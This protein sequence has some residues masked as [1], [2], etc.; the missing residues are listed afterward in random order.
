MTANQIQPP[1]QPPTWTRRADRPAGVFASYAGPSRERARVSRKSMWAIYVALLAVAA[2]FGVLSAYQWE[3]AKDAAELAELVADQ[4]EVLSRRVKEL[5]NLGAGLA[6]MVALAYADEPQTLL[7]G[8]D[9][10]EQRRPDVGGSEIFT[11][12]WIGAK[13]RESQDQ[14]QFETAS[15]SA[16]SPA[17]QTQPKTEPEAESE[18]QDPERETKTS[19]E[20]QADQVARAAPIDTLPADT[21]QT[22]PLAPDMKPGDATPAEIVL[23]A[24]EET[25]IRIDDAAGNTLFTRLMK[26]G[27]QRTM[28]QAASILITGN[29]VGLEVTVGGAPTPAF[30]PKGPTRREISLDPKRLMDGSAE[31]PPSRSTPN[32]D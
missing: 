4:N 15:G 17:V 28:P 14:P 26:A 20:S 1:G 16:S 30:N 9:E 27:E 12:L 31:L 2:A 21:Q 23:K 22:D 13:D 7:A 24:K 19:D 25:W 32:A 11:R 18:A 8:L 3:R 10:M 5:E 29:P 6:D